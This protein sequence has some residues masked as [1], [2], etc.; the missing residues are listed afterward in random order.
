MSRIKFFVLALLLWFWL[1]IVGPS[2]I[3]MGVYGF[4]MW[5]NVIEGEF[6]FEDLDRR[7]E[8]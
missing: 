5:Q 8:S 7:D 4:R 3:Q 6:V 1:L 2:I